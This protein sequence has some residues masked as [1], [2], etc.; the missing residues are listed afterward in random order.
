MLPTK[1]GVN[2]TIILC[3]LTQSF[4]A[5]LRPMRENVLLFSEEVI[6][7]HFSSL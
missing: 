7:L 2:S 3:S 6:V 5:A 4:P 1:N